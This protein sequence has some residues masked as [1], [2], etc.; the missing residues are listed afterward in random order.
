MPHIAL[1][2]DSHRIRLAVAAMGKAR[3]GRVRFDRAVTVLLNGAGELD[4]NVSGLSTSQLADKLKAILERYGVSRG[5]ATVVLAR[6]DVEMREL[7]LPPVPAEELPELVRFQARNHFTSFTDE[8]L[9]DYAPISDGPRGCTVLA[10]AIPGIRARKIRETVELAGLKLRHIVMR[11]FA[12]AELLRGHRPSDKCRVIL[13]PLWRQADISVVRDD[14][15]VLT[16]TV[17]VPDTYSDEQF[18]AWLPDE[19]RRTIAAASNQRG[20]EEIG[21]IVVCGSES[22]HQKL[23][24][25]L[26]AKFDFPAT[27]F[28]PFEAVATGGD[29][30][31]PEQIDGFASLLGSILQSSGGENHAVDFLNPRRANQPKLDQRKMVIGGS[32]AAAVLIL[33]GAWLWWIF[34]LRNSEIARLENENKSL[35][36][37]VGTIEQ[38][39][40]RVA[41]VDRWRAGGIDWLEELYQLSMLFPDPDEARLNQ[42]TAS[43]QIKNALI[44]AKGVVSDQ[45]TLAALNRNLLDRPFI[46][47]DTVRNNPTGDDQFGRLIDQNLLVPLFDVESVGQPSRTVAPPSGSEKSTRPATDDNQP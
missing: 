9:L 11:P 33:A 47:V 7:Q 20:A 16:R 21:E 29:F 30:E 45:E 39:A 1:N 5:D 27:F 6:G 28:D 24:D 8:W 44:A 42:L 36:E 10:M 13:E 32:I 14:Y 12:A 37:E 34:A 19:I 15:V 31:K 23:R 3:R 38:Q 25:E 18:D 35:L 40:D 17:R 41:V 46:D 26:A 43:V 4:A 22:L 2:W